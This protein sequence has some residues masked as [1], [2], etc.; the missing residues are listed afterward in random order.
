MIFGTEDLMLHQ[1][2]LENFTMT[3]CQKAWWL[4]GN[5]VWTA[6][7]GAIVLA[8]PVWALKSRI[9]VSYAES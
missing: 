4:G 2:F 7:T 3:A 6:V 9:E 1:V 5:L 8:V